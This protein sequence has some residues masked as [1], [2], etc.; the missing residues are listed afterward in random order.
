M[1]S[2]GKE[3]GSLIALGSLFGGFIFS[4]CLV[5]S[6]V[7]FAVGRDIKM[8]KYA[9]S[10]ELIF[11]GLSV[12]TVCVFALIKNHGYPFIAVYCVLYILYIIATIIAEKKDNEKS[13]NVT[14]ENDLEGELG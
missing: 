8:P 6:N 13:D 1:G 3:G 12:V 14:K 5:V 9:M 10:K 7:I 4:A 2:S 11:Y